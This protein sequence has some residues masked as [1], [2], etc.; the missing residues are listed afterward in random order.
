MSYHLK[1]KMIEHLFQSIPE[2]KIKDF[3]VDGKLFFFDTPMKNKEEAYK[4]T[5]EI[6]KNND[7]TTGNLLD[8]VYFSNHCKLIAVVLSR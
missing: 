1:M 4:K 2:V 6:S 3:I 8:H 5:I 7:Y